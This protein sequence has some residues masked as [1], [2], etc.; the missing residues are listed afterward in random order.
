MASGTWSDIRHINLMYGIGHLGNSKMIQIV[1]L[2]FFTAK[3]D[4]AKC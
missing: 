3:S 1:T 2:T 4:I